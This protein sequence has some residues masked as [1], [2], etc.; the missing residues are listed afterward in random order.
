MATAE[1]FRSAAYILRCAADEAGKAKASAFRALGS[2]GVSGGQL[3]SRVVEMLSVPVTTA[4]IVKQRCEELAQV[5][6]QRASMC[7]QYAQQL[8]AAAAARDAWIYHENAAATAEG[9]PAD[10]AGAPLIPSPPQSWVEL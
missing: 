6:D 7:D 2:H 8:S 3:E 4:D 9:R 5:C 10:L 1:E